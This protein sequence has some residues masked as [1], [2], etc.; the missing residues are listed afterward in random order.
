LCSSQ[1]LTVTDDV[2]GLRPGFNEG[3]GLANTR[4]C[5]RRLYGDRQEFEMTNNGSSGVRVSVRLPS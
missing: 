1:G 4:Q 2:A 5:L 3:A